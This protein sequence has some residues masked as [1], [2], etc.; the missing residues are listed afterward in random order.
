MAS[1][2]L[3]GMSTQNMF[4]DYLYKQKLVIW[5]CVLYPLLFEV[6]IKWN[7]VFIA[8]SVFSLQVVCIITVV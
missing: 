7:V 3:A 8:L 6:K 4:A 1:K 5:L 2:N